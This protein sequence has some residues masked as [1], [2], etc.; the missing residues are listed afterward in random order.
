VC[1]QNLDLKLEVLEEELQ[2]PFNFLSGHIHELTIHVP[3]TA[4]QSEPIKIT[5]NT[6]GLCSTIPQNTFS[7]P[8]SLNNFLPE[9]V[10]KLRDP[11]EIRPPSL[12]DTSKKNVRNE[13]MPG[14]MASLINKIANN[15]QL[16]W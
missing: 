1:F 6:I 15:I 2:L 8:L 12:K 9:F 7:S 16:T 11:S 14:I 3:W 13:E 5:I 4:L 10:L